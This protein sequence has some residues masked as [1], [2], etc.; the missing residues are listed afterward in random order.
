[1][2]SVSRPLGIAIVGYG[3]W[4]VNYVRVFNE[5]PE[6]R[7]VAVCDQRVERLQEVQRRF[8]EVSVTSRL[9]ELLVQDGIDAV[10]V[11]TEAASHYSVA[12]RC[13]AAG[14]HV[15][16]EKPITTKVDEA[17]ELAM[18]AESNGTVLMVGHTFIYNSA[19]RKVKEYISDG[20]GHIYYLH[21]CRTNLGPIRR[22]VN[23]LW[24]LAT[25]DIAI[26]NYLLD[27]VPDWVSAVGARVL[28][29]GRED[30]GFISL[31]YDDRILGHI[32]VSWADPNKAREVVVVCSDKRIVFNDLSG[33]EQVRV[34]EKGICP[35]IT[36]PLSYGEYRLQIRDGDILSPKI[37][38]SEPLKN[39]CRHFLE[40]IES[41]SQPLTSG[42]D[43]VNVVRVLKA[44]DRS[45]ALHG[46]RVEI[47]KHDRYSQ[48]VA[49]SAIG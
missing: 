45:V 18:F 26:F 9:E 37:E 44:M 30:V 40:C 21:A 48:T 15:L 29:N 19:V 13:L 16:V 47:E 43:G 32:H 34:F 31:G 38:V 20:S 3:Y 8:P 7:A 17:E 39:Q 27:A 22:D 24:D 11:C 42:W 41:G 36:E 46:A 33:L 10:V 49:A 4:G 25:H 6:A 23:A 28:K 35:L 2:Q 5:L 14:K 12:R 1:M